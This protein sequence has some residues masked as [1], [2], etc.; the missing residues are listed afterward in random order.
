M[1][2]LK[3]FPWEEFILNLN[4]DTHKYYYSWLK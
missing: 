3:S 4:Q 2:K 1:K